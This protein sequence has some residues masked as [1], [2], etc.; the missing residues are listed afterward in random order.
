MSGVVGAA[1]FNLA[2]FPLL[3][4]ALEH[5]RESAEVLEDWR[6]K[7]GISEMQARAKAPEVAFRRELGRIP[8]TVHR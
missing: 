2:A 4:S 1:G 5:Y 8:T 6:N 7:T 3:I